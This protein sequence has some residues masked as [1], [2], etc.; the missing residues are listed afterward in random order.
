[1]LPSVVVCGSLVDEVDP[2]DPVDSVVLPPVVGVWVVGVL[3]T[4]KLRD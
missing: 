3:L 2:V 4:E 1:M